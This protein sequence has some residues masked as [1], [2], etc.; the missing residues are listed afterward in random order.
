MSELISATLDCYR[1]VRDATSEAMFFQTYGNVFSL[2]LAD[3]HEAEARGAESA[4][5]PRELPFVKEAL[6]AIDRGGYPAALARVAFLLAH[7]DRPLPL[8]RVQLAQELLAIEN[9]FD[10]QHLESLHILQQLL[11]AH[12]A[13]AAAYDKD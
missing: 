10:Q 5:E 13:D 7:E 4:A 11:R 1:A 12:A 3:K 2:Y 8:A 9:L 6:A